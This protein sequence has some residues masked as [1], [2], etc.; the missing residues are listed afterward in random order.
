MPKLPTTCSNCHAT[1]SEFVFNEANGQLTC[2]SCGVQLGGCRQD[3]SFA[4]ETRVYDDDRSAGAT[5]CTLFRFHL[6][7]A[8]GVLERVSAPADTLWEG[9]EGGDGTA[10]LARLK[11][12]RGEA[13]RI[14]ERAAANLDLRRACIDLAKMHY[15]V[16]GLGFG[17]KGFRVL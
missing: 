1:Q 15:K 16:R 14:I 10:G 2:T 8:A 7:A 13:F 12:E 11:A 5:I 6:M 3:F 4:G 9:L 17:G